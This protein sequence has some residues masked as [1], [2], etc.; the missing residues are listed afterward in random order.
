MLIAVREFNI[1]FVE[2]S[3][4]CTGWKSF[5]ALFALAVATPGV[6]LKR[7][8]LLISF[9]IPFLFLVNIARIAITLYLSLIEPKSFAFVHNFL[10]QWGLILAIVGVW[11]VW[12]KI[13]KRI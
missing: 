4:D 8:V 9:G 1:A 11:G 7:K 10:W 5:Y 2:I 6:R 12:L 3:M 13:E